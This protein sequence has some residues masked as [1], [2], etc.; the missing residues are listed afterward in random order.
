[1]EAHHGLSKGGSRGLL[2][3]LAGISGG[4]TEGGIGGGPGRALHGGVQVVALRQSDRGLVGCLPP[5]PPLLS[6]PRG[7]RAHA[8]IIPHRIPQ[9]SSM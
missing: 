5:P 7:Q 8:S 1:M 2:T 9:N 4:P 6:T 3:T